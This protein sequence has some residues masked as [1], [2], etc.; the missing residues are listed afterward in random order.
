MELRL[1]SLNDF[2]KIWRKDFL[3][4][5]GLF[6]PGEKV[7]PL[8]Q[9]IG[10]TISIANE[11]WGKAQVLPVWSNLFGPVSADLPRGTFLK[12]IRA[13]KNLLEK[14]SSTCS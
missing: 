8:G 9:Q 4:T 6:I 12:I 11:T 3:G 7:F 5:E 13:D 14:I 1:T 2:L 10:L